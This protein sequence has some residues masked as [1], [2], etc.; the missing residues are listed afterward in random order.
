MN[1]QLRTVDLAVL[2]VYMV[3]VFGLGCWFSRKSS[4]TS[5]F[6]AAG[7]SLPGWAV[8]L[9]IFGTY[10]SSIGFLG[11]T[12][13]A[14]ADTWNS[15]VF[16]LTLPLAAI[17]AVRCF[18]PLYR[19][20]DAVSAYA[21][22]EQR[23]GPW[24]R[25]YALV[26]YLLSQLARVGT[27]L[28]LVALA[29]APLTG[30]DIRTIILITGI[31]V[32]VYTLLGGIEAVIWTDVAQS[33]VLIAGAI[34]CVVLILFSMPKGP[35]Q[36]FS[37][38]MENG[39]FSLGSFS[40]NPKTLT[41]PDP[42][43]WMVLLYGLFINLQNFGIDQSFV[44]RYIT[45]KSDRDATFSV[46]LGAI[47]FPL[48]SM[49]FFFIGTGLFSLY[50]S[51]R[52]LLQEVRSQVA[53]AQLVQAGLT[54]TEVDIAQKADTLTPADIGDKVL[55]HFIV[56]KLPAGL[57]GLLI[58][59]IFAAAMSSMDTSLNSSATLI[60]CDIY[61]RYVRPDA[62]ER[63]SMKVLY[64]STFVFGAVGTVTALAMIR[65]RSALDLW[66]NLQGIFTGGMLGLFLLGLISRKA[67]NPQAM[68]A[69]T[70][71]ILLILWLSISG[72]AMW[73][74]SLQGW[75]SPLHSSMTIVLGTVSIVLMGTI[76]AQW[77]SNRQQT[78]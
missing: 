64:L 12:G 34:L 35:S 41:M 7:R 44:Q 31:L 67:R 14:F 6:M 1:H 54:P 56:R 8:G 23:F 36:L 60:L 77:A 17:I 59:A 5:E 48:V 65:V 52:S 39:K 42:T 29:L 49:M 61:Q 74:Q 20:S 24:A 76:A 78:T 51:D 55:P 11:N 68:V 40:L 73:P 2:V 75:S 18:V 25:T 27:I 32:T 53:E 3:G 26:C 9:S 69:V 28:Y 63:E 30:W 38:A 13:K 57:A 33:F 72:T 71:G 46:W 62:G 19:S 37:V 45:A 47:L 43:F 10:V 22:L 15:W 50:H 70:V 4:T 66:W 58:A 16:G 21:H